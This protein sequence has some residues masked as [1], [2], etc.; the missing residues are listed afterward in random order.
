[1][2]SNIF[3][4]VLVFRCRL[5]Y[6]GVWGCMWVRAIGMLLWFAIQQHIYANVNTFIIVWAYDL[7]HMIGFK[8]TAWGMMG[9]SMRHN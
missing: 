8:C 3:S 2:L 9:E 6:G 5:K 4:I 7:V 1:M